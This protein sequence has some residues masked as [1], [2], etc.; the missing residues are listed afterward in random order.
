VPDEI[1][2]VGEHAKRAPPRL[3]FVYAH[4]RADTPR[5]LDR[6]SFQTAFHLHAP[7]IRF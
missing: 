6:Y 2:V 3:C 1:R 7:V 4:L 5:F